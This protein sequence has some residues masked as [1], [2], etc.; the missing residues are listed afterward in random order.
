MTTHMAVTDVLTTSTSTSTTT[1][2]V[3]DNSDKSTDVRYVIIPCVAAAVI[4]VVI[5][6]CA[7]RAVV[8]HCCHSP[9]LVTVTAPSP[10]A[11]AGLQSAYGSVQTKQSAAAA[12]VAAGPLYRTSLQ[13]YTVSQ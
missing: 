3:A 10:D 8:R 2:T 4:V 9:P 11:A 7:L 5:T 13:Y 1:S 6:I 12:D